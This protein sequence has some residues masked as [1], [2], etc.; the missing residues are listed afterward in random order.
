MKITLA[1]DTISQ[2][3]LNDLCT[4]IQA[5]NRLTKGDRTLEFENKFKEYMGTKYAI[6]V[7]S[8]SSANL[9]MIYGLKEAGHL[10]NNKVIAPAVSWVTTVSP[11]MQLG[12]DV[13]LCDCDVNDLGLDIKHFE[14]LCEKERPAFAILVHVLG[15]ANKI[16]Q[17]Q[18]IC[19]K[20]DVILIED[21][22]EALGSELSGKK[23]G[24]LSTAGSFSFY[25]G[26]HISTIEGGMVVTNDTHLYNVMVS[27]RSHGWSR[28]LPTEERL[29]LTTE[30]NIDEFRNL[31]TFYY[32]GFNLRSTDLQAYIGCGQVDKIPGIVEI[33]QRNFKLYQSRLKDFYCQSSDTTVLSSFAYGTLVANRIEIH[34]H[35]LKNNIESRPLICGN[36]GRHPFWTKEHGECNLPNADIIHDY[37]MYLPNHHNMN[38]EHVNYVCDKFL[39]VAKAH[40]T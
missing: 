35:L 25:Y 15:H 1:E 12:F 2:D 22:C 21:A 3:E 20:Y 27:L 40:T 16:E 19:K 39:E 30:N 9:M 17:I 6:Y 18:A 38:A 34:K 33:R 8:G 10:R 36:I 29:K 24:N 13:S 7:N 32:P 28:D 23:L 26:H 14:T 4:W 31:Y 11:L 5:G 37:G